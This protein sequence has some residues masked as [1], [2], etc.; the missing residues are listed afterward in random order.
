MTALFELVIDSDES[1]QKTQL[2]IANCPLVT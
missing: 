2:E 1:K